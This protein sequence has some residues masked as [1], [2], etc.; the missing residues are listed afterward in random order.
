VR[1][2]SLEGVPF[3]QLHDAWCNA[4]ADYA[5]GISLG[6]DLLETHFRQ[7]G[8]DLAA[9][10]GA[11]DGE[12][13]VGFW[14][15]GLREKKGARWAYDA[16]TAIVPTYRG[17]GISRLLAD[18]STELLKARG[19]HD[20]V[21]EVL[22]T[23]DPAYRVY[24]KDGFQVTRRF[25]CFRRSAAAG[26]SA[27]LSLGE[28]VSLASFEPSLAARLIEP[29]YEPS[30]QN[31]TEAVSAVAHTFIVAWALQSGRVVGHGLLQPKRGRIA[32]IAFLPEVWK[33]DLAAAVVWQLLSRAERERVDIVCV[34]QGRE[35]TAQLLQAT[36]FELFAEQWEMHKRLP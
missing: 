7:N 1:L 11:F 20:L 28:E 8:V 26:P 15:N 30:W 17:R 10:V 5:V 4:F 12:V 36:G 13:L 2:T 14:L 25:G 34:E 31:S 16:G 9:S 33:T 27:A 3:S 24:L 23:N 19:V 22:T 21:L 29:E 6:A 35:Q 18:H 32:Q